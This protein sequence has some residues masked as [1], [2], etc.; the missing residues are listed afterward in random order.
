MKELKFSTQ[1]RPTVQQKRRRKGSDVMLEGIENQIA[2]INDPTFTIER[3]RYVNSEDELENITKKKKLVAAKPRPWF[4]QDE[5]G[6][7]FVEL[8]YGSS[9]TF[10]VEKGMPS[11]ECGPDKSDIVEVLETVKKMIIEGKLDKQIADCKDR[12]RRRVK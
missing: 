12:A 7:W 5:S 3:Y 8:R 9:Y 11:I 10:E 1:N 4:W 6:S 2:F